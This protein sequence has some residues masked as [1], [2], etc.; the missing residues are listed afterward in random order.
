MK[1]YYLKCYLRNSLLIVHRFFKTTF[2][3]TYK[4]RVAERNYI[5]ISNFLISITLYENKLTRNFLS[6]LTYFEK[7]IKSINI[8]KCLLS[9]FIIKR[10]R[11][12]YLNILF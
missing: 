1:L 2:L 4:M 12:N 10:I 6:F 7:K 3:I 8:I 5:K 9:D 11:S